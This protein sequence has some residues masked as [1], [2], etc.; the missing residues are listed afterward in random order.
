M[1]TTALQGDGLIGLIASD[2]LYW[3]LYRKTAATACCGFILA[4]FCLFLYRSLFAFFSLSSLSQSL[5]PSLCLCYSFR[6]SLY[7]LSPCFISKPV[8]LVCEKITYCSSSQTLMPIFSVLPSYPTKLYLNRTSH[9][10][11]KATLTAPT[12]SVSQRHVTT[13]VSQSQSS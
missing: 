9:H 13:S 12:Y 5:S 4:L 2:R 6:L 8:K 7:T 11:P 10:L 3:T 1:L